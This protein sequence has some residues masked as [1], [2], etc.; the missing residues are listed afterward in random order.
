MSTM[1]LLETKFRTD[2]RQL[3]WQDPYLL[4]DF[5][6]WDNGIPLRILNRASL[7][8]IEFWSRWGLGALPDRLSK[9]LAKDSKNSVRLYRLILVIFAAIK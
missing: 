1:L 4:V 8:P 6:L 2:F 7:I 9:N 5:D 3:F